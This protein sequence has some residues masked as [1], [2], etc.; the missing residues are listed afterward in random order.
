MDTWAVGDLIQIPDVQ[1]LLGNLPV[2]P[3]TTQILVLCF[4]LWAL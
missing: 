2:T 4:I 3:F 1:E